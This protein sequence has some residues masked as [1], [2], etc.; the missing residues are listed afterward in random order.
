[1]KKP[2][3]WTRALQVLSPVL[4]FNDTDERVWGYLVQTVFTLSLVS[5]ALSLVLPV[6][7][8]FGLI[9]W[10]VLGCSL[11][12]ALIVTIGLELWD[13]NDTIRKNLRKACRD[14]LEK[15]GDIELSRYVGTS[16]VSAYGEPPRDIEYLNTLTPRHLRAIRRQYA[17]KMRREIYAQTKGI[18]DTNVLIAS[19]DDIVEKQKV[20][21]AAKSIKTLRWASD[22]AKRVT[23]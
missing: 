20:Q 3:S 12:A 10:T 2:F 19:I 16:F 6:H 5:S 1:M 11:V 21:E 23:S 15:D 14:A 4:L 13:D 18:E 9:S 8:A 7:G 17:S 22:N